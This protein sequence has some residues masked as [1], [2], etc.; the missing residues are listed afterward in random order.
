M[1]ALETRRFDD[2]RLTYQVVEPDGYR[3]GRP[4]PL[5][6]L[7]HGYGSNMSDLVPLAPMISPEG[8]LFAFPNAPIRL[9]FGHG[10]VGYA[11]SA[12]V[13]ADFDENGR[14]ESLLETMVEDV[15]S[16]YGVEK[17]R[18]VIGGFSQGGMMAFR[19]GLRHPDRFPGIVAL[20]SR[21]P[22]QDRP[23]GAATSTHTQR[24]FIAHGTIDDVIHVQEGRSARDVL[25]RSS[26]PAE[27]HEYDMAHQ[28]THDVIA[29]L[30]AWLA[31]T[32]PPA[33]VEEDLEGK[34]ERV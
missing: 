11:W 15:T 26:Y 1:A 30:S 9:D 19:H 12:P 13:E 28:I 20:S 29:D 21:L 34:H 24:I 31:D 33:G 27:Y 4:Y 3:A 25:S 32:L 2:S 10:M 7:M 6:I 18:V 22:P 16:R 8:C 14:A 17:G 23:T 5:V